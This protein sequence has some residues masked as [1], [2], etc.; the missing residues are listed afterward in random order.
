MTTTAKIKL[1]EI[2][3]PMG[4]AQKYN[5][6]FRTMPIADIEDMEQD[7]LQSYASVGY[8]SFTFHR[9][10]GTIWINRIQVKT[11]Q[12]VLLTDQYGIL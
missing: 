1:T 2:D 11:I 4:G 10:T 3:Y 9:S 12:D 5:P 8:N 6:K 7:D